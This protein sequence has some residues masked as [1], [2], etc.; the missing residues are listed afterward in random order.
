M[1]MAT[2]FCFRQVGGGITFAGLW[3]F[4][5][6]ASI[7]EVISTFVSQPGL[8]NGNGVGNFKRT[9]PDVPTGTT[10]LNITDTT[11]ERLGLYVFFIGILSGLGCVDIVEN[12]GYHSTPAVIGW[13]FA[14]V[15]FNMF[16]VVAALF[17]PDKA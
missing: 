14:G 10:D 6:D 3:R 9:S 4:K 17:A 13:F 16:A 7:T 8:H 1:I 12:K 11:M 5:K 2:C 15:V